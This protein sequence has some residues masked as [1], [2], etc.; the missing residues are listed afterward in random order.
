MP[1][2]V[3]SDQSLHCL[4][5]GFSIKNKI[6]ATKYTR[7]LGSDKTLGLRY[8]VKRHQNFTGT[9]NMQRFRYKEF[10][11]LITLIDFCSAKD[12]NE[13]AFFFF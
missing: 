3:A 7:H 1:H 6:K 10:G 4:L 13:L 12:M 8:L 2:N 5:A 11:L 9:V